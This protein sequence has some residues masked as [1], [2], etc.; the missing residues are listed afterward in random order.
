MTAPLHRQKGVDT[1]KT[2]TLRRTLRKWT[3]RILSRKNR[4][5]ISL[6]QWINSRRQ[7]LESPSDVK[8]V[9]KA[10]FHEFPKPNCSVVKVPPADPVLVDFMGSDFPRKQDEQ[11]AKIQS[12]V[13]AAT[14]PV[15]N[16]WADVLEQGLEDQSTDL[17]PAKVVLK[18]C[19]ATVALLENAVSYINSQRRENI[20]KS[21]PKSRSKLASILQQVSK[22]R[23]ESGDS[24]LFGETAMSEV[25]KRVTLLESFRRSAATADPK[26]P[27][28]KTRFLGKG[29]ATRYGGGLGRQPWY[30]TAQWKKAPSTSLNV[31]KAS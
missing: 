12:A 24:E 28:P 8:H 25:S 9:Y 31:P 30:P 7:A 11:L 2:P 21:L 13:T 19:K 1:T 17:I 29:P 26:P 4:P 16:L 18:T 22:K 20:I 10:M 3:Y 23:T 6:S 27:V 15:C 14:S 5:G